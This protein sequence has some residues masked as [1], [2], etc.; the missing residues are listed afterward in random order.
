MILIG[1]D[2]LTDKQDIDRVAHTFIERI[3]NLAQNCLIKK[4]D[5]KVY[6]DIMQL[7]PVIKKAR[8]T[9]LR[10]SG[11]QDD[12]EYEDPQDEDDDEI[13]LSSSQLKHKARAGIDKESSSAEV[14]PEKEKQ[15]SNTTEMDEAQ[16][17]EIVNKIK[18]LKRQQALAETRSMKDSSNESMF[19]GFNTVIDKIEEIKVIIEKNKKAAE[20]KDWRYEKKI[21]S[22]ATDVKKLERVITS[23]SDSIS[24]LSCTLEANSVWVGILEEKQFNLSLSVKGVEKRTSKRISELVDW[25]EINLENQTDQSTPI[26]SSPNLKKTDELN[27]IR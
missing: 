25:I 20:A 7:L 2:H 27:T 4:V 22:I 14:E 9:H 15:D 6:A 13:F 1:N 3:N 18:Q 17:A 10:I 24:D 5:F 11:I 26:K 12:V 8:R 23:I 19:N 21:S 16:E